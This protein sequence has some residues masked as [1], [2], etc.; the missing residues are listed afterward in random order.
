MVM[1]QAQSERPKERERDDDDDAEELVRD[2]RSGDDD[3]DKDAAEFLGAAGAT[4]VPEAPNINY[5]FNQG[6]DPNQDAYG[7]GTQVDA[8]YSPAIEEAAADRQSAFDIDIMMDRA[9]SENSGLLD[10]DDALKEEDMDLLAGPDGT[11]G[12]ARPRPQDADPLGAVIKKKIEGWT[13]PKKLPETRSEFG[14]VKE[15]LNENGNISNGDIAEKLGIPVRA[16]ITHRQNWE[17][18][19]VVEDL[20]A[21]PQTTNEE[22]IDKYNIDSR[23][24]ELHRSRWMRDYP[25]RAHD[26]DGDGTPDRDD[27]SPYL[28]S[29]GEDAKGILQ[30]VNDQDRENIQNQEVQT[31]VGSEP[32]NPDYEG[33]RDPNTDFARRAPTPLNINLDE[34]PEQE[35]PSG[36]AGLLG[37]GNGENGGNG[38]AQGQSQ[39]V[40]PIAP[41]EG[42]KQE[43]SGQSMNPG[44]GQGRSG[45]G[46]KAVDESGAG[47]SLGVSL[48]WARK[49]AADRNFEGNRW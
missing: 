13:N 19:K 3:E 37:F 33:A 14:R 35:K 1:A 11:G 38:G 10:F 39:G 36:L 23:Q 32:G 43:F 41:D 45:I 6:H 27:A 30:Q 47:F 9:N 24:M 42:L 21:N 8:T 44:Q 46:K 4:V 2:A 28:P 12:S 29:D 40:S 34:I 26:S 16:V 31:F 49:D 48:I 20:D 17:Y 25:L 7:H 22:L 15:L 18:E 5:G